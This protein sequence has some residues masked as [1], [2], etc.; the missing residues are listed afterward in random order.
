M[1]TSR[2]EPRARARRRGPRG[3][4]LLIV[5]AILALV[6]VLAA[7]ALP[8]VAGYSSLR[9]AVTTQSM[10]TSLELSLIN[11]SGTKPGF[12][13]EISQLPSHL[14]MLQVAIATSQLNCRGSAFKNANVSNWALGAP[15][16][17]LL[18]IPG[19][20]AGGGVRT[21]LGVIKDSVYKIDASN[22]AMK[23][24]SVG[25]ED[26]RNL[27]FLIDAGTVDSTTGNVTWVPATGISAGDPL[28]LVTVKFASGGNC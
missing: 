27:D 26:A 8:T 15:Y 23:I 22:I 11:A 12:L 20:A 25:T 10:L 7:A 9:R 2:V 19:T 18:I 21:P 4:A 28:H 16:S 5:V 17:G 1:L 3:V 14:S 13:E 24:D 6:A